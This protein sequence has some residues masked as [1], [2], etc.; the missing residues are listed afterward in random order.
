[1]PCYLKGKAQHSASEANNLRLIKKIRWVIDSEN[2]ELQKEMV[3][4][5][6]EDSKL[7]YQVVFK[8]IPNEEQVLELFKLRILDFQS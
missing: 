4:K 2:T 3:A 7:K 1:M 5:A 8:T 6:N